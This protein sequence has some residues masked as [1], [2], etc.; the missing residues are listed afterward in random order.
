M[1]CNIVIVYLSIFAALA[2]C[3]GWAVTRIYEWRQ[4][5]LY[6]PYIRRDP[7]FK[8]LALSRELKCDPYKVA[9]S[10]NQAAPNRRAKTVEGELELNGP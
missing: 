9:V 5:I 3:V 10:P 7:F 2:I 8:Q 6:G 4:D 1:G